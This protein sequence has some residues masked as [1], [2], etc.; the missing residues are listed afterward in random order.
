VTPTR[1]HFSFLTSTIALIVVA[2]LASSGSMAAPVTRASHAALAAAGAA[3]RPSVDGE[4][5]QA[6]EP[7]DRGRTAFLHAQSPSTG[8]IQA[9]QTN[10]SDG[11]RNALALRGEHARLELAARRTPGA[12][13]G[14]RQDGVTSPGQPAPSS[15]A[16]PIG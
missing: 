13:V 9:S 3:L 16:P 8:R 12:A 7:G 14:A 1:R 6:S 10:G 11:A 15:R 5:G 2:L 4:N